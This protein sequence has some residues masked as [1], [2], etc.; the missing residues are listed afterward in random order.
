MGPNSYVNM[1]IKISI[2]CLGLFFK[3]KLIIN[4]KRKYQSAR[5]RE[6]SE[7]RF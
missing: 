3:N 1:A 4:P 2:K 7:G 5:A 6:T